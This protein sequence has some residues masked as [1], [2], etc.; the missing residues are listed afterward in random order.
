MVR[1][2]LVGAGSVEFTRNLLG[3]FLSYPELRDATD[4]APRHRPRPPADGRADGD[5][6]RG[7]AGRA[8]AHRGA[9][10]PA[11]RAA[12]RRLRGQHDPGRRGTG[13][14]GRLRR[15][16]PL[17]PALHDQRH[18]Q[19]GRRPARP[20]HDP[21]RP[22]HRRTWRRCAPRRGS[23][24]TP[25]RWRCW[26]G[27]S[28]R[29][30]GHQD[31]RALPL[32]VLDRRPLAG[33]LGVPREEV[34]HVSAGVNHLAFLLRLE[35]RG[36]TCTRSSA[37]SST[38]AAFRTTTSCA[39]SSSAAWASTR[40]SRPST[41]RSTTRGS[42][43]RATVERF[44]VPIGEYLVPGGEQPRRVRRDEAEARRRRALRDRAGAASTRP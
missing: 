19:R 6:D 36:T 40:R 9:P 13:D 20:A 25:T 27:P 8:P 12:G 35:H 41:T 38:R 24:T 17:R 34:D 39:R 32:G 42:S 21:G 23:S 43:P 2:V 5:L 18:H 14:A 29:R 7:G 22:G 10:R 11:R 3:D 4:R 15:P 28:P 37:R 1:I 31:G 16:R 44:H 33:Y 30:A 26:S